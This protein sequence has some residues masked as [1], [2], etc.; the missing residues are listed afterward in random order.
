MSGSQI[1]V[2][3]SKGSEWISYPLL[4]DPCNSIY[5]EDNSGESF[6]RKKRVYF[7]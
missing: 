4:K 3:V 7:Q 6:G 2:I 5:L 1:N